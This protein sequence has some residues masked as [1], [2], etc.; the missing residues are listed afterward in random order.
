ML[1]TVLPCTPSHTHSR[2]T[3][4]HRVRGRGWS[5]EFAK[6]YDMKDTDLSWNLEVSLSIWLQKHIILDLLSFGSSVYFLV[7]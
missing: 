6:S 3:H 1:G 2:N 7:S 4:E 5:E